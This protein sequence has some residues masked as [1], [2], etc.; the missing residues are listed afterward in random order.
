MHL[1]ATTPPQDLLPV[2]IATELP[3]EQGAIEWLQAVRAAQ[4][5]F[6]LPRGPYPATRWPT[7]A[8]LCLAVIDEVH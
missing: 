5:H 2:G 7:R 6:A 8:P 1:P 3:P 4:Q